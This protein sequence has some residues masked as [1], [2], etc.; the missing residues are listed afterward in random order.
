MLGFGAYFIPLHA[1]ARH[2]WLWPALVFRAT[3]VALVWTI[4]VALR[5]F[6]HGVRPHLLALA[7]CGILDTGGNAL[8]AAASRHGLVSVVSVLASLYPV[9][10]VLL[11]RFLL[12]E[13]VQP[14]Q[15]AGVVVALVGVVLITAG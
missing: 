7:A 2:D 3:S 11:A 6:P 15:N 4:V 8:F 12:G 13:R 10:T 5:R 9:V 14:S 1:A